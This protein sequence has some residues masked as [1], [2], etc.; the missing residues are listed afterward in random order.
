MAAEDRVKGGGA[1]KGGGGGEGRHH[2][3]MAAL[4]SCLQSSGLMASV[5][6]RLQR[7]GR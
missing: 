7:L 4:P 6:A 3:L 1:D 5:E 2:G